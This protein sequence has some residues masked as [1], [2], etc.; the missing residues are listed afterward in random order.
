MSFFPIRQ[1]KA[2]VTGNHQVAEATFR[3]ALS[4]KEFPA[5]AQPG[6]FVML[7][8]TTTGDP[9]LRRAFSLHDRQDD[10]LGILYKVV[11][12]GTDWMARRRPGDPV[13]L[14]GPLGRGFS[15]PPPLRKALLV[16]GGMGIAPF[17]LLI[18]SLQSEG[19]EIL[20]FYGARTAGDLLKL[21][22]MEAAGVSLI[23]ATEDGSR[24]EK[25]RV[26][27]LFREHF[28]KVE[29]SASF[30]IFACGPQA[31][32]YEV[33]RIARGQ[34]IACEVSLESQMACGLGTCMGCVIATGSGYQRVC[35][36]GPVFSA[37][38]LLLDEI[39]VKHE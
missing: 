13:D 30:K 26:T 39:A 9:L 24:G 18:R 20:L 31:M 12:R 4:A 2:R 21:E 16:A 5:A 29:P 3:L 33:A 38:S 34:E 15:S 11:G 28:R 22:E 23:L 32:L 27:E 7:R 19:V 14:I 37:Q 25:G 1:V 17:R 35:R 8:T 6:Q 36:E 10:H